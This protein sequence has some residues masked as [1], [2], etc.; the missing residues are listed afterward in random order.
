M[1]LI[2][3][4]Q[5]DFSTIWFDVSLFSELAWLDYCGTIG[6]D[7]HITGRLKRMKLMNPNSLVVSDATMDR[8]KYLDNMRTGAIV[9][10]VVIHSMGYCGEL[11]PTHREVLRFIVQTIAVPVFFLV[12]GYLAIQIYRNGK[13]F[14]YKTYVGKCFRRLMVPWII[15][16][17][18][19]TGIRYFFEYVGFLH[20]QLLV[21]LSM[22]QLV[23]AMYSS[24]VAQQLYFLFSLFLV[25]LSLP[26]LLQA[27]RYGR[28]ILFLLFCLY[29]YFYRDVYG[30]LAPFLRVEHGV[31]PVLNA[32]WGAQFYLLGVLLKLYED[33]LRSLFMWIIPVTIIVIGLFKI[34]FISDLSKHIIQYCYLLGYFSLFYVLKQSAMDFTSIGKNTMGIYLLHV[35]ILMKI[36][37]LIVVRFISNSLISLFLISLLC[38][39]ISYQMTAFINR[40]PYGSNLFGLRRYHT[41]VDKNR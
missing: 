16:T 30:I 3:S 1:S 41:G 38:F 11:D 40:I 23:G 8:L 4:S 5:K 21:G 22:K 33:F 27:I 7:R 39:T 6:W 17:I 29:L 28:A 14:I 25:R 26:V 32:L 12:D 37:S 13:T 15:F 24:V 34:V 35:P 31:D 9:M 20:D 2:K 19:Y 18:I 10:V 36:I